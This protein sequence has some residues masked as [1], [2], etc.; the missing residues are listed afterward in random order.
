MQPRQR[1]TPRRLPA[2]SSF[3]HL[4]LSGDA[5]AAACADYLASGEAQLHAQKRRAAA[6]AAGSGALGVQPDTPPKAPAPPRLVLS[7]PNQVLLLQRSGDTPAS[8]PGTLTGS[9]PSSGSGGSG[10]LSSP[11]PP[12]PPPAAAPLPALT[13]AEQ[14]LLDQQQL[15]ELEL[16]LLRDAAWMAGGGAP[17]DGQAARA[18]WV[19]A[20]GRP[21]GWWVLVL[22]PRT[23]TCCAS[24]PFL[25]GP[26]QRPPSR[27]RSIRRPATAPASCLLQAQACAQLPGVA[28][29]LLGALPRVWLLPSGAGAVPQPAGALLVSVCL[30]V[31][32]GRSL[33][34]ALRLLVYCPQRGGA[35]LQ[36]REWLTVEEAGALHS[37]PRL[38]V[39]A[40]D[41]E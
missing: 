23:C 34:P 27:P 22:L 39:P 37:H 13:P 28:P 6:A 33:Q 7:Q 1:R 32:P 25:D 11:P 17:A 14:Q 20:T 19:C 16:D 36:C 21:R 4:V 41:S 5:A 8:E 31:P 40:W 35:L 29:R 24:C 38:A 3:T 30:P 15:Q 9:G 10:L 26:F 2:T 18:A 12:P